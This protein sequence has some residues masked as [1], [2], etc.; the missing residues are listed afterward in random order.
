MARVVR[1]PGNKLPGLGEIVSGCCSVIAL[2]LSPH[3]Y[4]TCI[5]NTLE[6]SS[7]DFSICSNSTRSVG[8]ST[9]RA[10]ETESVGFP[11]WKHHVHILARPLAVAAHVRNHLETFLCMGS[12]RSRCGWRLL[13]RGPDGFKGETDYSDYSRGIAL[14]SFFSSGLSFPL[15]SIHLPPR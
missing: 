15:S 14:R 6:A 8:C 2:S 4:T 7:R 12:I 13:S 11:P 3:I 10:S 1:R 9:H 5:S